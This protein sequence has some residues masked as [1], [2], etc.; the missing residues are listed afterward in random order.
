MTFDPNATGVA[1]AGI[2]ALP[3]TKKE[4]ELVIFP[5]PWEVTTSY[6]S[7]TSNGPASMYVCSRQID[8]THLDTGDVYERGIFW[9]EAKS[10]SW[11][12]LNDQL[13]PWAKK[14]TKHLESG[15]PLKGELAK[16]QKTINEK[17]EKLHREVYE[18]A[19][20]LLNEGKLVGL[21]GGDHS[22]PYGA[23]QAVSEKHKGDFTII[24]IDAHA[25]LRNSYQGYKHSHASIMRNVMESENAPKKMI[26]L[27]IRDFCQEEVDFQKEKNITCF[28]DRDVKRRMFK[29]ESWH[30]ICQSILEQIPTE[31]IYFSFDIDGLNPSLCKNTGTPVPGGLEFEQA[32]ELMNY[33]ITHKKK[34]IGFDLCEVTPDSPK[35]LDC[36]DGNVGSRM[37][38]NL[39]CYTLFS[40]K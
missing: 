27:G 16:M 15:K 35:D 37:L 36:W 23:I 38:Y 6:G 11:K 33:L 5:V 8:L 22:S 13:K 10:K 1:D 3:F 18:T 17:G 19:K 14:I 34:L 32:T 7:G 40:N 12:K 30:S 39:S 31:K 20:A 24:H 4:S 9:D 25:D 2:F 29:G 21:V 26:Q 28:F